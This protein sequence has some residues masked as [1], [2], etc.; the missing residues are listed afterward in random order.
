MISVLVLALALLAEPAPADGLRLAPDP[1]VGPAP[2]PAP[3]VPSPARPGVPWMPVGAALGSLAAG[4]AA[5]AAGIW[6]TRR[7]AE[8]AAAAREP[9]VV[10]V[11]GHGSRPAP[12]VFAHLAMLMGIDPT[13]ARY[14]DYRWAEGG[15]DHVRAS[16]GATIDETADALAGYLAGLSALGRPLYLVG[17]S[18]GGAGIAEL[19]ARWDRG[20]PG[21]T[22]VMG[23][24]LLDPPLA[25]GVHGFLQ[26]LGT[27]WGPLADDGGYRPVRCSLFSCTDSRAHLG[28]ASG[29][30]VMV[31]RNPQSGVA[32]F[33][34][35]PE[36]LRVYEAS[37]GGPGFFETLFTR[38]WALVGRI[39]EAHNAVLHD[40]RV[41]DCIAAEMQQS[42]TCSLPLAGVSSG[43]PAWLERLVPGGEASGADP[44]LPALV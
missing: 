11:S 5:L 37:D 26:S 10:F 14:F 16:Q 22:N 27:L 12:G 17:F 39:S 38:P 30:R 43:A 1:T 3:A 6:T 33:A 28:E 34:D 15:S 31:V 7:E 25:S 9:L 18:K 8:Q 19:V 4:L 2:A 42:V 13:E 32:N 44:R 23:A 41:A 29:V 35:V 20:Q 24:A 21:A 40:P 36:G